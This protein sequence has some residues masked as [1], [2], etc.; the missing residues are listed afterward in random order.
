MACL[1]FRV[2]SFSAPFITGVFV[3]ENTLLY[4][5]IYIVRTHELLI[6][7]R[8][9]KLDRQLSRTFFEINRWN[10]SKLLSMLSMLVWFSFLGAISSGLSARVILLLLSNSSQ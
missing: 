6:F 10:V 7:I 8:Q 4:L 3:I 1:A 5:N 9:I 2:I